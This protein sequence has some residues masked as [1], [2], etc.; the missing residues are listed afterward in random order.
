ML[1]EYGERARNESVVRHGFTSRLDAVQAAALEVKLPHLEPWNKR[2]RELAARYRDGLADTDISLPTEA[3]GRRH[4]YHL[5]VIR[6]RDRDT[7]RAGLRERGVETLLHYPR[8][9]HEHPA[10]AELG[11]DAGRLATS[12][13]LVREVVSLPLYPGLTDREAD[14]VIAALRASA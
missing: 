3:S 8:A 2:R 7:L 11:G 14:E 9:I 5:F 13:R 6:A 12:E 1:R 4:V 10:Y